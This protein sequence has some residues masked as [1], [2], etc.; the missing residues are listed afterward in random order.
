M[1][2]VP[3]K[4]WKDAF[5]KENSE[6]ETANEANKIGSQ[7]TKENPDQADKKAE[8][9]ANE[10]PGGETQQEEADKRFED[11]LRLLF[12]ETRKM[13]DEERDK[14]WQE[15]ADLRIHLQEIHR[16]IEADVEADK[17]LWVFGALKEIAMM[18]QKKEILRFGIEDVNTLKEIIQKHPEIKS[19]EGL[20][21]KELLTL[22]IEKFKGRKEVT[23]GLKDKLS[24]LGDKKERGVAGEGKKGES[25]DDFEKRLEEKLNNAI[26]PRTGEKIS[27]SEAEKTLRRREEYLRH[28]GYKVVYKG[29]WKDVVRI[30]DQ[31]GQSVPDKEKPG[32]SRRFYSFF[33]RKTEIRVNNFLREELREKFEE[34]GESRGQVGAEKDQKPTDQEKQQGVTENIRAE[35]ATDGLSAKQEL[36][37]KVKEIQQLSKKIPVIGDQKRVKAERRSEEARFYLE[38]LRKLG[39]NY[40]LKYEEG[41]RGFLRVFF[42][43]KEKFEVVDE[44]GESIKEGKKVEFKSNWGKKDSGEDFINF[45]KEELR[46]A[47]EKREGE[48][49]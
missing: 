22:L 5:Q 2:G 28:L 7:N 47:L 16:K 4:R 1:H 14:Y 6:P 33:V 23:E 8:K 12:P 45:L 32:K 15:N 41:I 34:R 37:R 26:D 31:N 35:G 36:E 20:V 24:K 11:R 3:E 18:G 39:I 49:E 38:E 40:C 43:G 9:T 21:Q 17:V 30:L 44:R 46:Q 13:K 27:L 42:S 19:E 29:F 10:S 48:G 25:F